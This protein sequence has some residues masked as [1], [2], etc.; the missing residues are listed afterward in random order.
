MLIDSA[1]TLIISRPTGSFTTM[2]GTASRIAFVARR[3]YTFEMT[4]TE[5]DGICC[6]FGSG[7]FKITVNGEPVAIGGNGDFGDVVQ[8]TFDVSE[9]PTRAPTIRNMKDEDSVRQTAI[10]V[11]VFVGVVLIAAVAS[12]IWAAGMPSAPLEAGAAHTGTR[13]CPSM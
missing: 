1:G 12:C 10:V 7:E 9:A 6:N 5:G 2:G 4:D 3:G 11:G 8:E 13:M